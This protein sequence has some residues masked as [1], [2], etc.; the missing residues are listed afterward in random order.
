MDFQIRYQKVAR[1][2]SWKFTR[3]QIK[4]KIKLVS[5]HVVKQFEPYASQVL[6]NQKHLDQDQN[7]VATYAYENT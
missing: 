4:E 6:C 2:F 7:M 5:E 1:P 3:K